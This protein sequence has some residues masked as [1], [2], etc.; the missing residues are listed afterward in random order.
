MA[1]MG[2]LANPQDLS[3]EQDK[4]RSNVC[5]FVEGMTGKKGLKYQE[6]I[7]ILR[8]MSVN[9]NEQA[10]IVYEAIQKQQTQIHL[11]QQFIS[12]LECRR[13]KIDRCRV[14]LTDKRR[15]GCCVSVCLR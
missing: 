3:A 9:K 14:G 5:L 8:D 7:L 4:F 11:Q 13:E 6:A 2:G 15:R 1:R 10:K 12:C